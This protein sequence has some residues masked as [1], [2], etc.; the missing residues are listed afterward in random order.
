MKIFWSFRDGHYLWTLLFFCD[1]ILREWNYL[2]VSNKSDEK[3][4]VDNRGPM[5][6]MSQMFQHSQ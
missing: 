4:V 5:N 6:C 2:K 3:P 1:T